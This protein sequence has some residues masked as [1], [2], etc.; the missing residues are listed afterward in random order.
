MQ[1]FDADGV[2]AKFRPG[3]NF[4]TFATDD[5]EK[6]AKLKAHPLFNK[7]FKV[8]EKG[9]PPK[10][11]SPVN[12][13]VIL[14][15]NDLPDNVR[16]MVEEKLKQPEPVE[17]PQPDV[18]KYVRFGELKAKLLRKDGSYRGDAKDEEI[19]EYEKLKEELNQ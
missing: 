11:D 16:A 9:K 12:H 19:T 3:G 15:Q 5:E 4:G 7:A 2:V 6:I 8:W 1:I 18:E 10:F 14:S 13:G 17:V